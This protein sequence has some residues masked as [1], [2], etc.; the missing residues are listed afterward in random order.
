MT[1]SVRWS[2]ASHVG[3]VRD[4]NED[5][6]FAALPIF[7]V[8]D[9]MGG[10][11]GGEVASAMA[12]SRLESFSG[13]AAVDTASL[14][15]AIAAANADVYQAR[16]QDDARPHMGTTLAGVALTR[17]DGADAVLVFNVGDSRVYRARHGECRQL[18]VDHS[19]VAEL[20][21][22][23]R[24]LEHE[25]A[26]HPERNVVTRVIGGEP[27]VEVDSWLFEPEPGDIFV[28]CSDGLTGE[29]AADEI[30][31]VLLAADATENAADR[32][33]EAA[34]AGDARDNLS[35][36]VVEIVEVDV[37]GTPVDEDTDPRAISEF[38]G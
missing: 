8:A 29:L 22:S 38:D 23:G 10:V 32:L 16:H 6:Y 4:N 14:L 35:V 11:N 21:A 24:I 20:V 13:A 37:V 34:L 33:V 2:A 26:R 19:V 28:A 18:T 7:A 36:I 17:A 27:K 15:G 31:R 3:N 1:I 30:S 5:A 25:A 12:V 9:G